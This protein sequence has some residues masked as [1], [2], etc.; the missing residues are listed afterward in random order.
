MNMVNGAYAN[1]PVPGMPTQPKF[2]GNFPA[3]TWTDLDIHQDAGNLGM[4]DGS[5]QQ[6]SLQNVENALNDT[7]QAWAMQGRL[8]ANILL[9]MP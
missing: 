6:A 4:A 8:Y 3:W 5:A 1:G 9:N 2:P 7:E